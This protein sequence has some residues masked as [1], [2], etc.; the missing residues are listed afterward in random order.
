[1]EKLNK[2]RG[3]VTVL[4]MLL[5]V[6]LVSMI[7]TFVAVSKE[8][9]LKSAVGEL[10]LV[11]VNS[12]LGEYDLNLQ[13]RYGIFGFYGMEGEVAGKLD[14]Y[15]RE[16][17]TDKKY[18]DYGGCRCSLYE[19]SLA[20]TDMMKKQIVTLGRL[21][22][23]EKLL[24]PDDGIVPAEGA[25][26]GTIRNRAILR[27]LPSAGSKR[28]V[29]ISGAAYLLKSSA[30]VKDAVK[31][32]TDRYFEN[33][34]LFSYYKDRMDSRGLGRTFFHNEIEYV[35]N[36]R[37][38]DSTN[39]RLTMLK[40]IGVREVMNLAFIIRDP[41]LSGETLAAAEL[42][43]PGPAAPVTQK[44]IQAAWALAESRNDYLLLINGGRVTVMKDADSWAIDLQ[45]IVGRSPKKGDEKD[46]KKKAA[47]VDTHNRSGDTYE[48]YLGFLAYA[49]DEE[50][51][52]LR[53]MDLMQINM[54]YCYYEDFELRDYS[55]GLKAV[56][57]VNG[58]DHE[59]EKEYQ[60]E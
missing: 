47:Y 45:S 5:F 54:K 55:A 37:P 22:A 31:K 40:L 7:L 60:P 58:D 2:K 8:T 48:D 12:I 3:S 18:V 34:Y 28:S 30:S 35:I 44:L 17:F 21:A 57:S 11:W 38:D 27:H 13:N 4:V 25:D 29:T 50:V 1:M 39:E 53:M 56:F 6:T 32:G 24:E 33:S 42:M 9:A 59:V 10:V 51:K 49:M 46:L 52:V 16:S 14:H 36:G 19:Y 26:Y 15:A 23:A 20:N 41:K 43:T